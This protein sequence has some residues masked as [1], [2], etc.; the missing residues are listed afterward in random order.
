[1]IK[2]SSINVLFFTITIHQDCYPFHHNWVMH[3][4]Q[5][6]CLGEKKTTKKQKQPLG[7]S[8]LICRPW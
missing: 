3:F 7:F 8:K 4:P 5:Y 6:N 1:M 2:L